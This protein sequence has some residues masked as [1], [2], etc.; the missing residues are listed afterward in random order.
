MTDKAKLP[1][2][3]TITLR[4]PIDIEGQTITTMTLREP[5]AG[6]IEN[7]RRAG[8]GET[9]AIRLIALCSGTPE[10]A[11]RKMKAR[12]YKEAADFCLGFFI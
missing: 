2:S 11:V 3:M 10:A 1:D 9:V 4:S 7:A 8:V 6:Q 12:D 5:T